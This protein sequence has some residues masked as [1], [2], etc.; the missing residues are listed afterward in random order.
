MA[1][2]IIRIDHFY[3]FHYGISP[4]RE[5]IRAINNLLK[6]LSKRAKPIDAS[7]LIK[8]ICQDNFRLY[9]LELD[10]KIVGMGSFFIKRTLMEN[11]ALIEDVVIMQELE[12]RGLGTM[13]GE[14]LIARAKE[15]GATAIELTSRPEREKGNALWLK[16]GF[17][18][19]GTKIVNGREKNIYRLEFN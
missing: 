15:E 17:K 5:I 1:S 3:G 11:E 9:I 18:K 19:I 8:L 10:G 16:L 14:Y 2:R 6:V 4:S 7:R 13:M 12:G